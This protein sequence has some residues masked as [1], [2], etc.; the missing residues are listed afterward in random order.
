[1]KFSY[2][3]KNKELILFFLFFPLLLTGQN[4][5]TIELGDTLTHFGKKYARVGKVKIK[6]FKPNKK[7]KILTI[8]DNERLSY[9]PLRPQIVDSIYLITK[10][11]LKKNNYSRYKVKIIS[12]GKEISQLIPG[13]F[14]KSKKSPYKRFKVKTVKNPLVKNISAPHI[15]TQGLTNRHIALWQSHGKY[16]NQ[17]LQKWVWQRPMIFHTVE[18]LYTQSYVIPFLVPMLENAGANVLLPRERDTQINE[19]IVDAE[20]STGNS[21]FVVDIKKWK[22]SKRS[23]FGHL[24]SNYKEKQNPFKMGKYYQTKTTKNSDK[25]TTA[26]WIPDIPQEGKYAV[27]VSYKTLYNSSENAQY[28]VY[29]L[30]GKTDFQVNQK[31]GGGTWIYLG[32]FRF[33]QGKDKSFR[34]ELSNISDKNGKVVTADAVKIGGGMGNI[35]RKPANKIVKKRIRVKRRRRRGRRR[36]W[37]YKTIRKVIRY[38]N[39]TTSQMPRFTEGARY[40]LQWAGVSDTVYSRTEGKNDYSDDFQSRG[41]WV[42]YLAGGSSVLPQKNGLHIPI[43]IALAFHSDAGANKND[44]TIGTLG[45]FT[46]ENRTK[47]KYLYANGKS[48][49]NVRE[50]VDIVQ[51]QIV[52]DIRKTYNPAWVRRGLWNRDYSESR[53][54]EV[55]TMLLEVISH[56]NFA[57]MKLGLDPRFRF[58]VSRAV[59]K[60]M[61]K[62]LAMVN[63]FS[64]TV[65]PLPIHSFSSFLDKKNSTVELQW[66]PTSDFLEPTA[67]PTGYIVYTR[68]EDGDFD[69]GILVKKNYFKKQL[70]PNT[71]YSFKVEAV[72]KGGKSFPSEILSV[73]NVPNDNPIVLIVNGFTKI[74][75]PKSFGNRYSEIAGF[76]EQ[77]DA[78]VPY[79]SDI[80]YIGK[81]TEF[82]RSS[83][84][85]GY[86]N[87]GF[88]ASEDTHSHL[89]IA[90]NTFD[91]PFV[92]GEAIRKSRFSF[93]STSKKALLSND[94]NLSDYLIVNFIFGKQ[95]ERLKLSNNKQ[96]EFHTFDPFLQKII[97]NYVQKGGNIIISGSNVVSDLVLSKNKTF[98]DK[99]FI[100]QILKT[101]YISGKINNISKVKLRLP[102]TNSQ[103]SFYSYPNRKCYFVEAPD[104]IEPS[105]KKAKRIAIYTENNLNAGIA[106][107]K[108][109]G[110][111]VFGFPIE[112]ITDK[113][114][115]AKLLKHTLDFLNK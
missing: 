39:Y 6:K 87:V 75:A 3:L 9:L 73:C 61:L 24:K 107:K 50:Y 56:Q 112:T 79:I 103:F 93:V 65:Q 86:K 95:S 101:K 59:Y 82:R 38:N 110:V 10:N 96:T 51:S 88:G 64:Y 36:R 35:A 90:G 115:R 55:P 31:M 14:R 57:D 30:G 58:T 63:N 105:N 72:N 5:I 106:Y 94:V 48:R 97:T 26:Q 84:Y 98:S 17:K 43:D 2:L 71:I 47:K 32:H 12:N 23:G 104:V 46:V 99:Y 67:E 85:K 40:W 81:Q 18:D 83:P 52:N 20:K 89:E 37:R 41:F 68:I 44:S 102:E 109:Y 33:P 45:I 42:N 4:T 60:G 108:K 27:Y 66:K 69:N 74:S 21:S 16:Y 28:S 8:V 111:V 53:V 22:K 113:N 80:H 15:A 29:H 92:H 100:E 114:A 77:Y 70:K 78:G 7:T 49:W 13:I 11:V 76:N 19:I 62:Y 1:M 25:S 34:I 54:P 91:Y